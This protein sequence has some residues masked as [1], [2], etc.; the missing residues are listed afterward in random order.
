MKHIIATNILLLAMVTFLVSE[1]GKTIH[2]VFSG[3]DSF[4][5]RKATLTVS[6]K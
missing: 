4:S 5:L 2:L 3:N 6:D 1:D